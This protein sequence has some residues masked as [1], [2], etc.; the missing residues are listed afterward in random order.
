MKTSKR[1]WNTVAT[2][3]RAWTA[4]KSIRKIRRL[5]TAATIQ[6]SLLCSLALVG[7]EAPVAGHNRSDAKPTLSHRVTAASYP[8]SYFADRLVDDSIEVLT[9]APE[10]DSIESWRPTREQ[11]LSMQ[12]SD[13][14]FLNGSAAPFAPWLPHV[15]L[16]D[17][18][19]C[20]TA[21]DGLALAEM[22]AVKDIR[23][24]HSHGP[25][26]EHSHPTMV[27][28]TWL[29]PAIAA[30][31]VAVMAAR[32]TSTYPNLK[33]SIE[34]SE[35][36]LARELG[37]LSSLLSDLSGGTSDPVS[38]LTSTPDLKFLT[39]AAGLND[40]HLNWRKPPT[41]T[42]ANAQLKA[43]ISAIAPPPT[44]ML[45]TSE[46]SRELRDTVELFNL[47]IIVLNPMAHSPSEGDYFSVMR[48]NLNR[49]KPIFADQ[50]NPTDSNRI[51]VEQ[52]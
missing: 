26:G 37:R 49:L 18:K 41:A 46:P 11:I 23:I 30:K 22:I 19:V 36:E 15:T 16:P 42:E 1:Y 51:D 10:A 33:P 24:V 21:N 35:N 13:I 39:R 38:V 44:F 4:L 50:Q 45:F 31:Q 52:N 5:A 9:L 40:V 6:V 47:S 7:C 12:Q 29:D 43:K 17:S 2:L 27:A 32:L 20:Q 8:M 14:V 3:A 34:A 28:Y 48:D 25:E